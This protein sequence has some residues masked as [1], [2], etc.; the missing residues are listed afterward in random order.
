METY[1]RSKL[2]VIGSVLFSFAVIIYVFLQLDWG[3]VKLTFAEI[4]WGWV[5]LAFVVYI[6]NYILRTFRLRTL[7]PLEKVPFFQL[8][9]LTGLYGMYNYLLPVGSGELTLIALLKYR[10]NISVV[11]G[12]VSLIAS[13]Y[14]DFSTIT[15]MLPFVMFI[16]WESLPSWIVLA[17]FIFIAVIILANVYLVY[18]LTSKSISSWNLFQLQGT[19]IVNLKDKL[20]GLRDGLIRIYQKKEYFW[21]LLLTLG[22]WFCVYTNYYLIV[23]SLGYK[24]TY[25]QIIVVSIIMI[26]MTLLPI[27]GL[28]NFGTHEIG[29]VI[30]FSIFSQ[31]KEVALNIAFSSHVLLLL[32]VLL[33]G[34]C[35][36]IIGVLAHSNNTSLN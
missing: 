3:T 10:L 12:M 8:L 21:L 23:I 13:R 34:L 9:S 18:F 2:P 36:Y 5:V 32:F 35:S 24:I 31:P 7:I 33:L 6:L 15:L 4:R 20:I 26:P 22:I 25:F 16:N 29:W 11:D 27:Q 28:A 30:A 17:S 14:F 1:R 19:W